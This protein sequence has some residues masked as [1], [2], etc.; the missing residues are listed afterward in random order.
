MKKIIDFLKNIFTLPNILNIVKST[1]FAYIVVGIFAFTAFR[2][3]QS[4][5]DLDKM[6]QE[7]YNNRS[8]SDIVF[9]TAAH[10]GEYGKRLFSVGNHYFASY[11]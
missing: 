4:N 11:K 3:C 7:E 1:T 5:K 8:N 9:F 10:Y 2:T 6:I